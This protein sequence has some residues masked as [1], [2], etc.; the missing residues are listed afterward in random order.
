LMSMLETVIKVQPEREVIYIHAARN[1]NVHAMKGRVKDIIATKDHVKS[2]VVYSEPQEGNSYDQAGYVE[3]K[4]LSDILPTTDASFYF[5]G[6]K[7][8]MRAQYENLKQLGVTDT[9]LH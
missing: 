3:A 8:F 2:Y 4:W 7:A 1:E 5:C 6:P 9:D